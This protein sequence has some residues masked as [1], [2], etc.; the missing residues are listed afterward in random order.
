M[1]R[2]LLVA[3]ALLVALYLTRSQLRHLIAVIRGEAA[4]RPSPPESPPSQPEHPPRVE[5]LEP[6][7]W[8]RWWDNV[9]TRGQ[10]QLHTHHMIDI[11]LP[12]LPIAEERSAKRAFFAGAGM[13]HEVTNMAMAGIEV[14]ALDISARVIDYARSHPPSKESLFLMGGPLPEEPWGSPSPAAELGPGCSLHWEVGDLLDTTL[15]P[16]PFDLVVARSTV[17]YLYRAGKLDEAM[18]ALAGRL[19]EQGL[20]VITNHGDVEAG[21]AIEGWLLRHDFELRSFYSYPLDLT[22]PEGK[23]L[24]FL[25]LPTG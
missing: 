11:V 1:K 15:H 23:R 13:A 10:A 8:D 17:Q 6:A 14:V 2:L 18:E 22:S 24:A 9:F 3:T 20:L 4:R 19:A 7:F 21:R 25:S 5:Y 12:L 16:G